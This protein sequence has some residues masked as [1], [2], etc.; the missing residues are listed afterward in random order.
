MNQNLPKF[1]DFG[2]KAQEQAYVGD[3]VKIERILNREIVVHRFK[4]GPSNYQK[5]GEEKCM[6]VQIE[7]KGEKAIFFTSSATLMDMISRIPDNNFPFVATI[8]KINDRYEFV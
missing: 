1:K 3:K 4:I 5:T 7:L 2:I 8:E 6:T